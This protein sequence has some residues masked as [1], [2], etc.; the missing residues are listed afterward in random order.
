[1]IDIFFGASFFYEEGSH[2]ICPYSEET[3][4]NHEASYYPYPTSLYKYLD[5]QHKLSAYLHIF[6]C[7]PID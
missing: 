4:D 2:R 5:I 6:P 1:M 7:F 3:I